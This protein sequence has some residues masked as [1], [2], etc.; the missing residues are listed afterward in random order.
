[1][2][3]LSANKILMKGVDNGVSE[4]VNEKYLN[5]ESLSW[6][7]VSIQRVNFQFLFTPN[8]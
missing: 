5:V 7:L 2:K 3:V 6:Y 1:M 8:R 4:F